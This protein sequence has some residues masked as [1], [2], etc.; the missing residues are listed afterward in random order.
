ML[1]AQEGD[2]VAKNWSLKTDLLNPVFESAS[3]EVERRIGKKWTLG[4]RGGLTWGTP[5]YYEEFK[6]KLWGYYFKAGPKFYLQEEK[7][8]ELI[9]FTLH[10]QLMFSYWRDY[11]SNLWGNRGGGWEN[12]VGL[13]VQG[14]Y[15]LRLGKAFRIEPMVG[16]GYAATFFSGDFP[17][18]T[19]VGPVT[20]E[21][22]WSMNY[23]DETEQPSRTHIPLP[24]NIAVSLG[25]N[26][27]IT[28]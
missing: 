28:F 9:G 14:S 3:L 10:P 17:N 21:T 11:D 20:Y 8:D 15:V 7:A 22:R 25:L 19:N 1:F 5:A 27:G 24:L 12:S 6:G 18:D 2:A 16:I 13:I 26:F 4:L 23:W